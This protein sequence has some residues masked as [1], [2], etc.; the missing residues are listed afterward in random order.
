MQGWDQYYEAKVEVGKTEALP[1]AKDVNANLDTGYEDR[2]RCLE[3]AREVYNKGRYSNGDVHLIN[4]FIAGF[5]G[6]ENKE[7]FSQPSRGRAWF[8]AVW[9]VLTHEV[10]SD[11]LFGDLLLSAIARHFDEAEVQ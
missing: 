9:S 5:L 7:G 1:L 4:N 6:S 3:L 11:G 10:Q 2:M 8:E